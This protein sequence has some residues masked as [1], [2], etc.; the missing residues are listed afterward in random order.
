MRCLSPP[1]VEGKWE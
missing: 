1:V